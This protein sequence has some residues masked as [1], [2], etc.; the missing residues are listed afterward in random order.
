MRRLRARIGA[1]AAL[2]SAASSASK[3]IGFGL[4]LL[5]GHALT[6]ADFGVLVL[7]YLTTFLLDGIAIQGLTARILRQHALAAGE[8]DPSRRRVVT[9]AF[10]H[11][12]AS[13]AVLFGLLALAAGPA[14]LLFF[15][16]PRWS[17]LLQLMCIA[18]FLRAVQN[19]PRQMLRARGRSGWLDGLRLGDAV[20]AAV[21]NIL[22]VV[23]AGLGLTGVVYGEVLR[24][25]VATLLLVFT[26]R[27]DLCHAPSM[28]ALRRLLRDGWPRLRRELP[29]LVLAANDRYFLAFS[30]SVSL[31]GTYGFGL[32]LA[33]ALG[34][35]VVQPLIGLVPGLHA[36]DGATEATG[37]REVFGRFL[38]YFV[39]LAGLAALAIAVF[40]P[41]LLR[42]VCQPNYE[43]TAW[44]LPL[45]LMALAIGGVQKLLLVCLRLEGRPAPPVQRATFAAAVLSLTGN[46][47]LVPRHGALGAAF[48]AVLAQSLLCAMVLVA[49]RRS[50]LLRFEPGRLTKV[51]AAL[52]SS[53]YIAGFVMPD[54][55]V[56]QIAAAWAMV[57]LYPAL[58][59]VFGFY[60]V[61]EVERLRDL[62]NHRIG[63][64]ASKPADRKDFPFPA[65]TEAADQA[66]LVGAGAERQRS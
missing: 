16:E 39:A 33:Q 34:D 37:R 40:A 11:T 47:V 52:F 62:F 63:K 25:G 20:A 46:A 9:T 31:I 41:S 19:V 10:V 54:D 18:G 65:V 49:A 64:A 4:L 38:T 61:A 59:G 44:I 23:G 21:L 35:F 2:H 24:E 17:T 58:L 43:G 8:D 26:L 51:A 50:Q 15:R 36:P 14:S 32:R 53:F 7:L 28:V 42:I 57:L 27:R 29:N 60:T 12:V 48:T 13:G 3:S 56:G 22:L 45:L 66:E 6:P 5:Y 55:L 1:G 30:T